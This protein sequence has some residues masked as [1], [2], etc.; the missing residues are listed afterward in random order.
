MNS[1]VDR[2]RDRSFLSQPFSF[3]RASCGWFLRRTFVRFWESKVENVSFES[4]TFSSYL[5]VL[6]QAVWVVRACNQLIHTNRSDKYSSTDNRPIVRSFRPNRRNELES[7]FQQLE[8]RSPRKLDAAPSYRR[9]QSSFRH[10]TDL[11]IFPFS[12]VR[13]KTSKTDFRLD[14]KFSYLNNF[15][16]FFGRVNRIVLA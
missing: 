8:R 3:V 9:L 13:K 6:V 5:S 2:W 4:K 16:N 1:V 14:S 12:E 11:N 10:E 7:N 15:E